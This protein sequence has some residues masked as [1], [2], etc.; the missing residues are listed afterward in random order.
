MM[1]SVLRDDRGAT[2]L[3]T[4]REAVGGADRDHDPCRAIHA[5]GDPVSPGVRPEELPLRSEH[6]DGSTW[7]PDRGHGT[8]RGELPGGALLEGVTR[9]R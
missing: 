2:A 1:N 4:P 3:P 6:R 8:V 5:I 9:R 7:P